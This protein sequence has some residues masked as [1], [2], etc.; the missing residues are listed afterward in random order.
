MVEIKRKTALV[1][2]AGKRIGR[3]IALDLA[4]QG[5]DVAVHYRSSRGEA[6]AVVA[7]I[8]R[9]GGRAMAFAADLDREAEVKTLVPA[10]TERVKRLESAGV[11]F[12]EEN[13][14]GPGVRLRKVQPEPIPVEDLNASNDE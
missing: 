7:E 11:I 1:T 8:E 3:A 14:Q 5:W 13:G 2:G 10:V 4:G 6:D 9:A 12:V